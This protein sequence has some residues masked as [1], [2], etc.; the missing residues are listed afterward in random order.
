MYSSDLR[1][2]ALNLYSRIYSLRKVASLLNTS[3][4]TISRW[5]NFKKINRKLKPKKLD[6]SDIIDSIDLFIKANP[7][8]SIKDVKNVIHS[9]FNLNVSLELVRLCIKKK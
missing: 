5:K 7:F 6:G 9:N 4:S 3:F 2:V 1:K 8:C